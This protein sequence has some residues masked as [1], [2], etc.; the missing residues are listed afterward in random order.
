[1]TRSPAPNHRT[2]EPIL[3]SVVVPLHNEAGNVA[4]LVGAIRLA[5]ARIPCW[6]LLL[7]DDG[8][9]DGTVA[10][11]AAERVAD[12][13]VRLLRLTQW[14]GQTAA[15]RAGFDHAYGEVI[16]SMDGDLQNDPAEVPR[17]LRVLEQG[18][19]MVAGFR[20]R[21]ARGWLRRLTSSAANRLI[22]VLTGVKVRDTGCT[23]RAYRS[24]V[25]RSLPLYS[26]LHRFIPVLAVGVAGARIA[27]LPVAERRRHSGRSKYGIGRLPRV[28]TDLVTLVMLHSFSD[29]PFAL[30]AFG[31]IG[32]GVAGAAGLVWAW[33]RA[34]SGQLDYVVP[35]VAL[36]C[37]GQSGFLF[38]LGLMAQM[39]VQVRARSGVTVAAVSVHE[40]R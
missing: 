36:L 33:A 13:R 3:V 19:D 4:P 29:R 6:E 31:G 12:P 34:Q 32:F 17:F 40:V 2:A 10:V 5:L 30:F 38:L 37:L 39:L 9:T 26:E 22:T 21:R 35:S 8:S 27:E 18:Y 14:C 24:G 7:V 25:L 1:M 20:D 16:V 28:L 11:A 23:L 15:L